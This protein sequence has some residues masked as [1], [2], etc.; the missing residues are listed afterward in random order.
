M[1]LDAP[2]NDSP[3]AIDTPLPSDGPVSD[4]SPPGATPAKLAL[5]LAKVPPFPAVAVKLLSL[6]SDE[7]KSFSEI[8]ACI[9][10]D[11]ALSGRLIN[12]ANAADI[13]SYCEVAT[14]LQAVST[15]GMERTR[16]I[17]LTIATAVYARAAIQSETLQACWHHTLASA[18]IAGELARLCGMRPAEN[19]TAGLLHDIGR[20]GLITAYP[21]E[22]EKLLAD[23]SKP[24]IE[25]E[26]EAFGVDHLQAGPLLAR[27]WE[28]PASLVDIIAHHA[29]PPAGPMTEVRLVHMA[30]RLAGLLDFPADGA[31]APGTF[32]EIAASLPD[33]VRSRLSSQL[34]AVKAAIEREIGLFKAAPNT[35][36]EEAEKA[37]EPPPPEAPDD[38]A[39]RKSRMAARFVI[40]AGILVLLSVAA[41]LL[42]HH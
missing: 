5:K 29:Q 24:Q 35:P 15:L 39:P 34:P 13:M 1:S 14:V 40:A 10:T 11:P 9:A 17:S 37:E 7:S 32:D 20:L 19:Y 4:T 30:C 8:A 25:L 22:Y 33:V 18:L 2:V 26:R 16:E 31:D 36:Q 21:A 28:L 27:E 38:P 6:L 41:F 23:S 42:F 3:T 12:R